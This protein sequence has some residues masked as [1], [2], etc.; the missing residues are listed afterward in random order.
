MTFILL[1]FKS[2]HTPDAIGNCAALV[3]QAFNTS[4]SA[5]TTPLSS[6]LPR[7]DHTSLTAAC[8]LAFNEFCI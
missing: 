5:V 3:K 7:N 8:G 2:N 1:Q 6:T 4:V